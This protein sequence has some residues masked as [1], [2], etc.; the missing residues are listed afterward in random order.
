M[1]SQTCEDAVG[2][3]RY[4]AAV[5]LLNRCARQEGQVLEPEPACHGCM[6]ARPAEGAKGRHVH[7]AAGMG[8]VRIGQELGSAR[9]L[10]QH[11]TPRFTVPALSS[12]PGL[13]VGPSPATM[14]GDA[15]PPTPTIGT[16]MARTDPAP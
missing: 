12:P 9:A 1:V 7:A 10:Q 5:H 2:G 8:V 3:Q 14:I 13:A 11:S 16:A 15:G 6:A 4:M